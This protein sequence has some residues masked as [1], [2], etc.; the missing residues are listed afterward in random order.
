[1]WQTPWSMSEPHHLLSMPL[2]R[3]AQE[4]RPLEIRVPWGPVTVLFVPGEAEGQGAFQITFREALQNSR[5]VAPLGATPSPARSFSS[6]SLTRRGDPR[7]RPPSG[8]DRHTGD[9]RARASG[10]PM[11][12]DPGQS[13]DASGPSS[14]MFRRTPRPRSRAWRAARAVDLSVSGAAF[15]VQGGAARLGRGHARGKV[16]VR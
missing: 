15:G 13:L 8:G 11:S 4:G 16:R 7:W 9:P 12:V 14:C 10:G 6:L 1:M 5:A 2:T 3:F